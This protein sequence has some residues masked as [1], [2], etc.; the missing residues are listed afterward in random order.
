MKKRV[1]AILLAA[2]MATSMAACG[3]KAEEAAPAAE[4]AAP[5]EAS[6]DVYNI[7]FIVKLTDGHFNK[8]MAGAQAYA[9]EHDNV[10]VEINSPTSATA[11]D[12]QINMI[13][14]ALSNDKID[15]LVVAPLQ[16]DSAAN[17]VANTKK[18]VVACD[19]DFTSDKKA[20]FVGT[21]NKDAA[22][23]GGV[24]AVEA[25]KA[26]GVEKPT[27]VVLTG[28]QGDE[29]HDARL[30]G[31]KE[32]AEEAGGEVIEVQYCDGIADKA[33]VSM[34]AVMQKFQDGVDVVLSTND[35]MAMAA[36][37]VV[38]DSGNAAYANTIICG[39]DG[40]QVAIEAV[41]S[42]VLGMDVAQL[43]WDM[44]Y[45]A[46]E[47]IVTVLEGGSVESFTDSGSK[48]VDPTNADEYIEDMKG[49]GLWE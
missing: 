22:K 35:D 39:F 49:K 26:A 42:G 38:T 32:G 6:D 7:S 23:S 34:E 2:A 15:G 11:Y 41:K 4:S 46:M 17:L 44:G 18:A 27:V 8:V 16:S 31:Y 29:T 28:V 1:I 25:A 43:G 9:D 33:S 12:E 40:N 21:G 14:T 48:V 3:S 24:A 10:N 36:A 20:T 19:T 5:A 37:K 47:A 45:K 13:E 30:E